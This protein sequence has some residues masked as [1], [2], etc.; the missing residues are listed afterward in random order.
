MEKKSMRQNTSDTVK[1]DSFVE[2]RQWEIIIINVA[3]CMIAACFPL[4]CRNP[5][6]TIDNL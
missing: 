3:L 6:G 4:L 2:Q 5:S 1:L